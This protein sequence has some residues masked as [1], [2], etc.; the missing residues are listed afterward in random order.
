MPGREAGF[1]RYGLDDGGGS[2]GAGLGGDE[3]LDQ[4]GGPGRGRFFVVPVDVDAVGE[5]GGAQLL[6]P[7]IEEFSCVAEQFVR[8]VAEG[9]D[10]EAQVFEALGR[11]ADRLPEQRSGV[12]E[13]AVTERRCD[14]DEMRCGTELAEFDLVELDGFGRKSGGGGGLGE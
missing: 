7:G 9:Q 12:G 13:L 8:G 6:Q 11:G 4:V 5:P 2:C 1:G 3:L 14:H 10:C